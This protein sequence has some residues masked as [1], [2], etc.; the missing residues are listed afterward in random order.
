MNTETELACSLLVTLGRDV[1][2]GP[3]RCDATLQR[4]LLE[5]RLHRHDVA[6]EAELGVL[7]AGRDAD[8][9]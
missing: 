1:F 8:E 6:L 9:L 5:H 7:E 3:L 4:Q 2:G